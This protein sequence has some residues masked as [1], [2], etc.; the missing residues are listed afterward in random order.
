VEKTT[1]D[2]IST[3]CVAGMSKSSGR[4]LIKAV[5][6]MPLQTILFTIARDFSSTGSHS[7]MKTQMTYAI[8]C[9]KPRVFNW[10]QGLLTN[11]CDHL[12]RCRA[13]EQK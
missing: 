13:G 7:A 11:L 9:T 8:E 1:S 10:C 4:I 6:N 12:T 3:Y 5:I 2:Y